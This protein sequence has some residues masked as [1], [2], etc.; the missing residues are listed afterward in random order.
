MSSG[1]IS[2][3]T[4][5]SRLEQLNFLWNEYKYRHELCWNAVYKFTLGA[6]AL[7][8]VPYTKLELAKLLGWWMLL[9]PLLGTLFTLF[10]LALVLVE[11]AILAPIK[12]TYTPLQRSYL[13]KIKIDDCSRKH[14]YIMF[15]RANCCK[16]L[17]S[18]FVGLF[19]FFLFALSCS[20]FCYLESQL[21]NL[22]KEKE[23]QSVSHET[24]MDKPA[25]S[26]RPSN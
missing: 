24:L 8:L 2:L 25:S 22:V 6:V 17:F 3:P 12:Y 20:N 15:R 7:G 10:G 1:D 26:A 5:D 21:G 18:W 11:L 19:M 4:P 23:K 14:V 13:R 9:P 16:R